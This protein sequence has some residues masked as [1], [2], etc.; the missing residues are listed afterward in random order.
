MGQGRAGF[1][2]Y[3]WIENLLGAK[4][5]NLDHIDASLQDLAVDPVRLTPE[6]YLGRTPGSSTGSTRSAMSRRWSCSRSFRPADRRAGPSPTL[7]AIS[8]AAGGHYRS[9]SDAG[10]G[11]GRQDEAMETVR[12]DPMGGGCCTKVLAE[13]DPYNDSRAAASIAMTR[14]ASGR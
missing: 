12:R 2:T 8:E 5:H 7:R 14:G 10:A 13:R 4:I 6:V 11:A 3:E 1:Y 9:S